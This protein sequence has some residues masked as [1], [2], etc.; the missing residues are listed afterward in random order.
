MMSYL[1]AISAS[2][3]FCWLLR[4]LENQPAPGLRVRKTHDWAKLPKRMSRG[5]GGYDLFMLGIVEGPSLTVLP[6]GQ[7]MLRTGVAVQ[8]PD[9]YVGLIRPRSSAMTKGWVVQGTIDCDYRGEIFVCA[10]NTSN[11]PLAIPEGG[12]SLAQLIIVPFCSFDVQE[13]DDLDQTARGSRGFGST[14][15]T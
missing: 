13:V 2:V 3:V 4:S 12:A 6:G 9:G 14:G 1:L 10:K 11:Q 15:N 7:V 5:A 8:I